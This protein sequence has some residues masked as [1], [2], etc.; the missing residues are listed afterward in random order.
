M[1]LTILEQNIKL[2]QSYQVWIITIASLRERINLG[3]YNA[4]VINASK[5]MYLNI[6]SEN[7]FQ[8]LRKI[9]ENHISHFFHGLL[10]RGKL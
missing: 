9:Q 4:E 5:N 6:S 3:M 1:I 8:H 7:K 2:K 10:L